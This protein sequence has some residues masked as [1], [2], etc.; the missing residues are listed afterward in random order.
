MR[1]DEE[2]VKF[3]V[4]EWQACFEAEKLWM[5]ALESVK[6]GVVVYNLNEKE[7]QFQNKS[8]QRIFD[9]LSVQVDLLHHYVFKPSTDKVK[10]NRLNHIHSRI[11]KAKLSKL[12][13]G[14]EDEWEEE[15]QDLTSIIQEQVK[16]IQSKKSL[17]KNNRYFVEDS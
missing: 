11:Y 14:S 16:Q 5:K 12:K 4:H 15:V 8:M 7:I 10:R 17:S 1:I 13:P 3:L 9:P 2:T 6:G